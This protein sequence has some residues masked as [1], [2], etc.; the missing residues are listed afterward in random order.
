[1]PFRKTWIA[2]SGPANAVDTTFG[3]QQVFVKA[4]PA[5]V[6]PATEYQFFGQISISAQTGTLTVRLR[7]KSGAV[8]WS[9]DLHPKRR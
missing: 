5:K 7:D 8:L 1:M 4:P 9:T 2:A 3:A 6:S